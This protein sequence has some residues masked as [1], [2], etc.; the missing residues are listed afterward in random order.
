M[1]VYTGESANWQLSASNPDKIVDGFQAVQ[2]RV[3]LLLGTEQGSV[4]LLPRFG[5]SFLDYLDRSMPESIAELSQQINAAMREFLPDV[6]VKSVTSI[7][8]FEAGKGRIKVTWEYQA[9]QGETIV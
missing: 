1:A 9:E 4:P 3:A 8:D 7:N 2:Q 5:V 6:T